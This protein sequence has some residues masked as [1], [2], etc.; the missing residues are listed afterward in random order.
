MKRFIFLLLLLSLVGMNCDAQMLSAPMTSNRIFT[1]ADTLQALHALFHRGRKWGKGVTALAPVAI[2]I[3]LYSGSRMD[4]GGYNMLGGNSTAPNNYAYTTF[5]GAPVALTL[6]LVGPL[7]WNTNTK[8]TEQKIIRDY[9][10]RRPLNKRTQRRLHNQ[11]ER[12]LM[13]TTMLSR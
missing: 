12:M 4:M 2:G 9:E 8:D 3:V 11:L 7:S 10:Q 1:A 13:G 6:S 5:L